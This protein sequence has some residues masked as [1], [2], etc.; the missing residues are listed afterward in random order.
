MN[1]NNEDTILL[2]EQNGFR[3]NRTNSYR[4]TENITYQLLWSLP[5]MKLSQTTKQSSEIF[6]Q[7]KKHTLLKLT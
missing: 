4:N 2:E 1:V 7:G 6:K 3:Q 5:I